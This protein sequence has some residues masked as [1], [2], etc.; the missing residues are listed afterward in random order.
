MIRIERNGV[1]V[2]IPPDVIEAS[3]K[4]QADALER[5]D[6]L[7]KCEAVAGAV[8]ETYVANL[9]TAWFPTVQPSLRAKDGKAYEAAIAKLDPKDLAAK[10]RHVDADYDTKAT[11]YSE[12]VAAEASA[13]IKPNEPTPE[14]AAPAK[15]GRSTPA[16]PESEG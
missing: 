8:I 9:P 14:P 15:A 13:K 5:G 3:Y 11:T 16:S 10:Q 12:R 1:L 6:T 4:A 2:P 7:E